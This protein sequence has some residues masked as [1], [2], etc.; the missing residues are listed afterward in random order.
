MTTN[1]IVVHSLDESITKML[2]GL[3]LHIASANYCD[4]HGIIVMVCTTHPPGSS[5]DPMCVTSA[6]VELL[7]GAGGSSGVAGLEYEDYDEEVN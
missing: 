3:K 7:T 6:L 1:P 4:E 5:L 2:S